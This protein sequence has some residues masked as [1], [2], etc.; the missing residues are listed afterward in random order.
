MIKRQ[1]WTSG[2]RNN[3]PDEWVEDSSFE[4]KKPE[5]RETK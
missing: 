3:K 1:L 4:A 2:H 5:H